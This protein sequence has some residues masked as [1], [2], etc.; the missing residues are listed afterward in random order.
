MRSSTALG[1]LGLILLSASAAQAATI[2]GTVTGPDGAP[3][4]AA[5]VQA[6]NAATKI[7]VSV[8]SDTQGHYQVPDLPA[9]DYRLSIRAPGYK[10]DPKTGIKLAGDQ[11]ASYDFAL[12]TGLVRWS[13]ISYAQGQKLLPDA[14]GKELFFTHC[15]ACHGF[16]SRMAAV[17]R[18]ADGWRDR[19]S[20]MREAM[21]FFINR[22]QLQF[23]DQKA[24]TIASYLND[25]FGE[26]STAPR[27]PADL[28]QYQD[29]VHK[30]SDEALK[31]V[32]V[33]YEMPGPNRMPWSAYPDKDGKF[34]IPITGAPTGSASSIR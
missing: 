15:V 5:F 8:L 13:D 4:R 32:Y 26:D 12:Q 25:V 11:N 21:G 3:F 31:I 27:S 17:K 30:F 7:T 19:V 14:P 34:W 24:D 28:P 29:T 1:T 20:Y 9:G 10:S 16:E 6:R 23:T 18:D 33:E 2:A 22:P